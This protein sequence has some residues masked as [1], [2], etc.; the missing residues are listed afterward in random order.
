M[1]LP[2]RF[3]YREFMARGTRRPRAAILAGLLTAAALVALP[4]AGSAAAGHR[5]AQPAAVSSTDPWTQVIAGTGKVLKGIAMHD[6]CNGLAVGES[7]DSL[8]GSS[9][10]ILRTTTG[11][12][13]WSAI[14]TLLTDTTLNVVAY[15]DA[16]HVW[17]GGEPTETNVGTNAQKNTGP[18]RIIR[19]FDGGMTWSDQTANAPGVAAGQEE[20]FE[21]ITA[22]DLAT[23]WLA[24]SIVAPNIFGESN[25]GGRILHTSDRGATWT[26][27]TIPDATDPVADVFMVN[28]LVGWAITDGGKIL[29]TTNGGANG[30]SG[31]AVQFD[32]TLTGNI[33]ERVSA[34]DTMHAAVVGE[35]GN[36]FWTS[37]GGT[38]W[39][40][41]TSG[42]KANLNDLVFTDA[43]HVL[44]V[45]DIDTSGNFTQGEGVP[46]QILAS[47]DGGNTFVSQTAPIAQH[48]QGVSV[49]RGTTHAWSVGKSGTIVGNAIGVC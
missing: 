19:S 17:G 20:D 31:W 28:A 26:S 48:L 40:A 35:S 16:T 24:A 45:G 11:G 9:T 41:G 3:G 7:A 44:V 14:P 18:G 10:P 25:A 32:T 5:S 22:T 33:L 13:S 42:T 27:Q 43:T 1:S 15:G 4:L 6:N 21:G 37:N 29:H 36:V 34:W 2:S 49:V 23:A 46:P 38:T 30:A 39:T 12:R 8:A 47:S